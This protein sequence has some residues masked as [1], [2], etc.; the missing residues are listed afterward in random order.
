MLLPE[1]RVL[2]TAGFIIAAALGL[3]MIGSILWNDRHV[4]KRERAT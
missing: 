4:T 1:R 3:Y 2:G